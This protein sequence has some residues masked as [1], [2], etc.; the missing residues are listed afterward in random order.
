LRLRDFFIRTGGEYLAYSG[1]GPWRAKLSRKR[2]ILQP[3]RRRILPANVFGYACSVASVLGEI[4]TQWVSNR[5]GERRAS[6]FGV[7]Y[8]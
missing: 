7:F 4:R 3:L 8:F 6:A 2:V 1:P 5:T